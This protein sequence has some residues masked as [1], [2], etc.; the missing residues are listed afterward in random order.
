MAVINA[1]ALNRTFQNLR[2]D[3]KD[4]YEAEQRLW[5]AFGMEVPSSARSNLYHW[6]SDLPQVREW[7]GARVA[8][9][10]AN[11]TWDVPNRD[12]EITI[13]LLKNDLDDDMEGAIS[14]AQ[15]KAQQAGQEFAFH[16]D[17]LMADTLE[18]GISARCFDGQFFFDTD[19]P[20]DPDDAASTTFDNDL[21][22]TLTQANFAAARKALMRFKRENGLP[23]AAPRKLLLVVP[24]DI[25][26]IARTILAAPLTAQGT[27][28][29]GGSA[30]IQQTNINQGLAELQVNP[31]LA[32]T[33]RWYLLNVGQKVKP[34]LFQRRQAV[35]LVRKDQAT[36]DN[37]FQTKEYLYGADA[38]YA[39]SYTFPHLA[40]TS[41]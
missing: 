20:T 22:G 13:K 41:A 14:G 39:A 21:S 3:F 2:T 40:I 18:A 31:Y 35:N 15:M 27:G 28:V 23:V 4:S 26:D 33:S 24:P 16:E 9:D 38:R 37:V 8:K 17:K 11:R 25:E 10:L 32:S 34:L 19:H 1:T 7:F 30:N 6:L 5:Q 36:D 12:W 29:G